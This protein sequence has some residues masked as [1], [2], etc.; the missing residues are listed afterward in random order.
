MS[1][2]ALIGGTLVTGAANSLF[3][4]Y[5]DQQCVAHCSDPAT[6]QYF[7]QPAFQTIQMFAGEFAIIVAYYYLQHVRPVLR[8]ESALLVASNSAAND[9]VWSFPSRY[10]IV[11]VCDLL[12]TTLLNV[13]LVYTPVL[14]YQ[15]IRGSLVFFVA[16]LLIIFLKRRITRIEWAL[17]LTVAVGVAIVGYCG[18]HQSESK[19][20][21]S[22]APEPVALLVVWGIVMIVGAEL[23][24][25]VQLV[26][27]EH[28]LSSLDTQPLKIVY[29][30]GA[31]GLLILSGLVICL[32]FLVKAF[33]SPETFS[34]SPFNIG[35][36]VSQVF[37]NYTVL[38]TLFAIMALIAMFNFLGVTI[39]S[40]VGATARLTVDITRTLLV[41]L[42]ALMMKWEQFIPM[43]ALG[44]VLLALGTLT[45]NGVITPQHH[46]W[47]P[48][49]FRY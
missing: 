34:R 12:A 5:Q 46:K 1:V 19:S 8:A 41:W 3:T 2:L 49:W 44:F 10:A 25:S 18:S 31:Y 14:V 35:E 13:G 21:A 23:V 32:N 26:V 40:R 30:E 27:E 20:N 47:C 28:I 6:A 37:G 22:L 16:V 36:A 33:S 45:F 15:M 9:P 4:K 24:Q 48:E 29:C 7:N 38:W 42:V 43:Q 11:S 39:T 17:L